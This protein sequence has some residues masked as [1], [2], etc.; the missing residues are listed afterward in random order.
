M[1]DKLKIIEGG[2]TAKDLASMCNIQIDGSVITSDTYIAVLTNKDGTTT[3]SYS[4]NV[5]DVAI[6]LELVR[7]AFDELYGELTNEERIA[8]LEEL[9]ISK[10]VRINE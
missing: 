7:G 6:A 5:R 8:F 4:A 1:S 2:N 9:N 10:A 3:L